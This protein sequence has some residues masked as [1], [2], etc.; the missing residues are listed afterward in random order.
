MENNHAESDSKISSNKENESDLKKDLAKLSD[1]NEAD[2]TTVKP[3]TVS[4]KL[5]EKPI[6]NE[7][8]LLKETDTQ[9]DVIEKDGDSV[10]NDSKSGTPQDKTL[11]NDDE[12]EDKMEEKE[13]EGK[14]TVEDTIIIKPSELADFAS[15]HS[16]LAIFGVELDLPYATIL[17]L[18]QVFSP[19]YEISEEKGT[20]S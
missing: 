20:F 17:D 8:E 16:F 19:V 4:N 5:D 7:E 9:K 13:T 6:K 1:N 10:E 12:P 18:D 11:S 15:I 14:E 2:E 3:D